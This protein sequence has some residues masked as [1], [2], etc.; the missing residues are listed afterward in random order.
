[1]AR[2]G[3]S[4]F[5]PHGS[6]PAEI[7]ARHD[8]ERRSTA[9]LVFRDADGEQRIVEL[10][11]DAHRLTIGRLPSSDVALEWDAEVSRLH[12][13]LERLGN[14]WTVG[15]DGLSR[16]GTYV[17]DERLH[18]RRRLV[19]GDVLR[20][21]RTVLWYRSG[22]SLAGTATAEPQRTD[23][24]PDLTP[25]QRRVLVALCR[26]LVG[27]ALAV[28]PSNQDIATE[29]YLSV[30]AVKTHLRA[31]FGLFGVEQVPQNQKRAELARRALA[32]G[33]VTRR[34]LA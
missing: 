15:D 3:K 32:S 25:A 22:S 24:A 1:M 26:P 29:L 8:A 11:R 4:P 16:N 18:G 2:M 10:D 12:A 34:E 6:S 23:P 19:D 21:G 9:F 33:A 17:N 28:P 14:D 30:P 5:A 7:K 31:L 13:A 27:E 20:I